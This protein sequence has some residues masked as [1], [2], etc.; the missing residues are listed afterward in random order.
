MVLRPF[1]VAVLLFKYSVSNPKLKALAEGL[2]EDVVTGLA[3]FSINRLLS[4]ANV[5]FWQISAVAG[6]TVRCDSTWRKR[7][8]QLPRSRHHITL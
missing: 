4:P 2:T 8:R 5:R 6:I 7:A 1:W 3:R